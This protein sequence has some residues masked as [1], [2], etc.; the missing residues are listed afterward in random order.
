MVYT[1]NYI[2]T[3]FYSQ[4]LVLFTMVPR[5]INIDIDDNLNWY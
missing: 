5:N 2:L 4:Y 1:K 3:Y